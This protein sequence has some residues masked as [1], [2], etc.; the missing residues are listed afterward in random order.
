LS[1]TGATDHNP[2]ADY[3]GFAG[4]AATEIYRS[5]ID[6]SQSIVAEIAVTIQVEKPKVSRPPVK[7]LIALR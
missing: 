5:C 7:G 3:D 6:T 1:A 4:H 2:I